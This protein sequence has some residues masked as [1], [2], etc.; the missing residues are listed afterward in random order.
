VKL[1]RAKPETRWS[2]PSSMSLGTLRLACVALLALAAVAAPASHPSIPRRH[3]AAKRAFRSF[4]PDRYVVV[5][6]DPPVAARFS[7]RAQAESS[8][9]ADYRRQIEAKQAA[10]A[11]E[12]A[13]RHIRVTSQVSHL[14]NALFVSAPGHNIDELRAI[15]GVKSVTP[16]RRARAH[17]N[18]AVQLMDA[19]TAWTA[20]G[21]QSNAGKGIKIAIL[22]SGI[23]LANPAFQDSTLP[24]PSG[25]P[26]CSGFPIPSGS[27]CASYTNSKVIVARSY[28]QPLAAAAGSGPASSEP[29]DPFPHD[30]YGHGVA[31]AMIA[32]GNTITAPATSATGGAITIGGMAPK[33]YIGVYKIAGTFGYTDEEVEVQALED[34][35]KD[36]MDVILMPYGELALTNWASDPTATAYEQAAT[37][38][39]PAGSL[40]STIAIPVIVAAAGNDGA[41]GVLAN[42]NYPSYNTIN[43]PSNAP[44]VIS[45]GATT[46]A[47]IMQPS[48]SV[49]A[50]GA[51]SNLK[52]IAAI[53]G[54]FNYYLFPS[55]SGASTAPLVDVSK[56]GDPTACTALSAGSLNNSFALMAYGSC[57]FDTAAANAQSA[58]AVG[59]VFILPAGTSFAAFDFTSAPSSINEYGPAVSISNADGLN[60]QSYIDAN[61]SQQVTI[62]LAGQ[63]QTVAALNQYWVNGVGGSSAITDN[64]V[65]G[66]SSFGP[67]PDGQLKPDIVAT[68][69]WDWSYSNYGL[70]G[71]FYVPTQSFDAYDTSE[72]FNPYTSPWETE[73]YSANGF[74]A[75]DGTS[76]SAALAAGAAALVIQA[77][78]G[79]RGTEV[80]SLIVNSSAQTV[81][82]DDSS[83]PVDAEW[84]GAGLLDAGAAT[85]ATVTAEPATVSFG[86]LQ[87]GSLPISK[88]ITLTNISSGS[89]TLAPKVSCCTVNSS[90][91][92]VTGVTIAWTLSNTTPAA[93]ATSTL[94]VT[95][96][97]SLPAA[98]EYSGSVTFGSGT[99]L[100]IPFMLLVGAGSC[101][102][103]TQNCNIEPAFVPEYIILEGPPSADTG[104]Y[105]YLQVVDQFGVPVAGVPVTFTE[106]TTGSVT[107]NSVSGHPACSPASS[108]NSVTCPT[109][110]FGWA[111]MDVVLGSTVS[112]PQINYSVAGTN[113]SDFFSANIQDPPTI[114]VN[115]AGVSGVVDAAAYGSTIAP[116]SYADIFG[117]GFGSALTGASDQF[118]LVCPNGL[119]CPYPVSFDYMTVSF[120]VPGATYPGFPYY[121]LGTAQYPQI[122]LVVPRE[123]QGQS[124][125]QVKVSYDFDLYSNVVTVPLAT[126][127]PAFI[128]S[129]GGACAL[130]TS[131]KVISTSNPAKR[132]QYIQ[133]YANGLGPVT[134][135]PGDG[136]AATASPL[137]QTP[138]TP[139]VTIGGAVV[140]SANVQFSG[141]APGYPALYQINVLVPQGSQTG[142]AVPIS[143][144][145]GGATTPAA[146]ISVQ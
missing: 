7:T 117:G 51:P 63:E 110:Q 101:S 70:Y 75:V 64:M 115:S 141:L 111:W 62:D 79:L 104:G 19:Q 138:T 81:A 133:L 136:V 45:V 139:V 20:V 39:R 49:T 25:F 8:A 13:G 127:V 71:G 131:Y 14:L 72:I 28:V 80:R 114:T 146:T 93:G 57:D 1:N 100:H 58:G 124:S 103:T 69:G 85:S 135:P 109:D 90:P 120:D 12:L 119:Y 33:A 107:M 82:T 116:G 94:T 38:A 4:I 129:C 56:I 73:L 86:I 55:G 18:Q 145:I 43:S 3:V 121:I 41:D 34:A 11:G 118:G 29:D 60:L 40:A 16:M 2:R 30:R 26:L 92:S 37:S 44:D 66:Y 123:L 95:L 84:I 48:V 23:D 126:Y 31:T 76:Y 77:H 27:S 61:P 35:V 134:N 53:A 122:N 87:S 113:F 21:G 130:D 128:V 36:G 74:M 46:N 88:T 42:Y 140:P 105:A 78:P 24:M 98:G 112:Q 137:S 89:V 96:G 67:T 54:L 15:P 99:S 10:V 32:A 9:A 65:P 17:L 106:S 68:G 22:D 52:H 47:H 144:Q 125:A 143:L 102:S 83:N 5:L 6:D 50:A 59:F 132:G 142:S 97:G 108:T 91:G